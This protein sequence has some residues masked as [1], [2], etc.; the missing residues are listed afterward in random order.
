VEGYTGPRAQ[1]RH[2]TAFF[3]R[4]PFLRLAGVV[5]RPRR[6]RFI[7]PLSRFGGDLRA[8]R[9]PSLSLV[10]PSLCHDMHNCS[11]A[12]GDRWLRGFVRPLLRSPSMRNSVLV[13]TFD[14]GPRSDRRGGG[15]SVPTVVVGPLVRRHARSDVPYDHYS[16]LRTIE[17]SWGLPQLGE[18]DDTA[19]ITGIWRARAPGPRAEGT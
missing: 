19:P 6:M 7:E 15:G 4:I 11:V 1:P 8:Q 2:A 3:A 13:L 5:D 17:A 16:L 18:S 12:T 10:V 14:E 9:L